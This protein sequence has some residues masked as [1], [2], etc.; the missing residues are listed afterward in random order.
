MGP[1]SS[2]PLPPTQESQGCLLDLDSDYFFFPGG[3]P[4]WKTWVWWVCLRSA[5]GGEPHTV[6]H[7]NKYSEGISTGPPTL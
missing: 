1:S 2:L 7:Q 5:E 6:R 3:F 4:G